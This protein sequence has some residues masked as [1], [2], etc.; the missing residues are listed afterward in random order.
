MIAQK[1]LV[2]SRTASLL[3]EV[4]AAAGAGYIVIHHASASDVEEFVDLK[5]PFD[6][7][8][9]GPVFDSRAGMERL[10]RLRENHRG[11]PVLLA[12][13]SPVK[14]SLPELV[15]A[16]ASDLVELP[17]ERRHLAAALR[18]TLDSGP[19]R[20]AEVDPEVD[21]PSLLADVISV[22]SPSGGCGKTFYSTNLAY[23]LSRH[24]G[25]RVCLV[26]LD[27][28]FGEVVSA[29]RLK[30]RLTMVDAVVASDDEEVDLEASIEDYLV[31][32]DLGFWVL[33][34]P[35][36]PAEAD[37]VTLPDVTRIISA[38]RSHFDYVVVDTS[39]QLSEVTLTALEQ[40]TALICMA[41][42][43][44]PSI[45]N[46]RIFLDT[47]ER[48]RVPTD[49]ISVVLNKVE[50]DVGLSVQEV[51]EALHQ[52]VVAVLPYARE[53]S[54]SINRGQPVMAADGRA[55]ISKKLAASMQAR[56]EAASIAPPPF[57]GSRTAAGDEAMGGRARRLLGMLHRG[58]E[59]R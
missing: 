29:L 37:R 35:R 44:V 55:D 38:L 57:N 11:L 28:Q 19:A 22:A 41:T 13:G 59:A 45:R 43:D 50:S 12:L 58:A 56:L 32:H 7:L 53:V 24:S 2:V 52:K 51:N 33:A 36:H 6:A 46:M 4:Q 10:R 26:D 47:L 9:A 39:A 18:R 31:A 34:A 8:V 27:L 17:V 25:R 3:R 42:V 14:A 49:R 16:G 5:G 30:P 54:R 21:T 48:L 1:I 23:Y 40:S 20:S 15:R